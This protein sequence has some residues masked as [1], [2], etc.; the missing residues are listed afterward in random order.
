ME[1]L[2][3]TTTDIADSFLIE[4][5]MNRD[6]RGFVGELLRCDWVAP[7]EFV[8]WNLVSSSGRTLRGMHWHALHHD[9][10]APVAGRI[11]VGLSDLRAGSPTEGRAMLVGLDAQDPLSVVVPPGVAHGFYSEES[12]TTLYA[13]TRYWDGEDEFGVAFDDPGLGVKWPVR[14]S[15]V[16]LSAR[17]AELPGLAEG[18][19]PPRFQA[20]ALSPLKPARGPSSAV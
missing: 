18:P 16:I 13:V 7:L 19:S 17:D 15:D 1:A 10:I 3:Y 20:H 8:Q 14:R 6:E 9:L 12:T 11:L 2:S 5:R 4:P